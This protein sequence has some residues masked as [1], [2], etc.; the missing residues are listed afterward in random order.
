MSIAS[1][2]RGGS[3]HPEGLAERVEPLLRVGDER[4]RLP[5]LLLALGRP[6]A[7]RGQGLDL[8]PQPGGPLVVQVAAGLDHLLFHLGEDRLLVAVEERDEPLDVLPVRLLADLG[9]ARGGTLLDRVE[10]ARAEEPPLVVVGPDVEVAGAELEGFLQ[11]GD[12]LLQAPDAGERAVQLDAGWPAA[13][14]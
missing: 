1:T 7:E 14:G 8:V 12:G 2:I 10:Q 6:L 13:G 4:L 5:E 11:E 3:G 9:G